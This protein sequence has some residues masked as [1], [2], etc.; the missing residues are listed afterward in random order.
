[1]RSSKPPVQ[2]PFEMIFFKQLCFSLFYFIIKSNQQFAS[3]A[4]LCLKNIRL[5]LHKKLQKQ[6][7][8]I[9]VKSQ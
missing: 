2:R 5:Q 1:M 8:I 4:N 3:Y 9:G 7:D 6:F